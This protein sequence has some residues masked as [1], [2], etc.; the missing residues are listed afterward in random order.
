VMEGESAPMPLHQLPLEL[1]EGI[2]LELH[3]GGQPQYWWLIAAQ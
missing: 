3:H 1:P 2:E